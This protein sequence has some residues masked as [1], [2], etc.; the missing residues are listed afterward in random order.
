MRC[1]PVCLFAFAFA[2]AL[3]LT[4]CR[5]KV[6]EEELKLC[7][8]HDKDG[9]LAEAIYACERAESLARGDDEV[10][11]EARSIGDRLRAKRATKLLEKQLAEQQ[12]KEEELR[13]K[14]NGQLGGD[15][16]RLRRQ[17]EEAAKR[18]DAGA[19]TKPPNP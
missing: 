17:L 13:S 6:A 12:R 14:L 4:S 3:T 9:N 8:L 7:K 11:K 1:L 16:E 19:L 18:S 10:R 5:D 2:L 15:K